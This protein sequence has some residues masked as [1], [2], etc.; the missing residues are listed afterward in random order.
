V[1]FDGDADRVVYHWFP[2]PER[3]SWRLLDGDRIAV[4]L[5]EMVQRL[6]REGGVEG[7]RIGVV[8][9]AYANG[10]GTRALA[11]IL[12]VPVCAARTGVKFVHHAAEHF[13][14]GIYFEANGHGTILF[15]PAVVDRVY[16]ALQD[17]QREGAPVERLRALRRLHALPRLLNQT[18]GD[19]LSDM[20]AVEAALLL[21]GQGGVAGWTDMY[22]E[23]P[24]RQ[25]K[26]RVADRRT[27][28]PADDE[29]TVL[30]PREL[31]EAI[32]AAVREIDA[33]TG[34]AFVRP[35]GTEDVVR[36]YAEAATQEQA[37]RL[38]T[39][40]AHAVHSIA[41]GVDDEPPRFG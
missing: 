15:Q 13:D 6:L 26:V 4:L 35:S 14:V 41:G 20:L 40:A 27:V 29:R 11:D 39:R 22:Q 34:R 18:V 3:S 31:Q 10:A 1:S 37:D 33:D 19:A 8:Q 28:V 17:A 7:V 2:R 24:S 23:L 16:A 30:E 36:I 32:D 21:R 5:G 38:A 12:G 25:G 9:T